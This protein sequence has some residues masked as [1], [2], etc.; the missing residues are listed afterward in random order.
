MQAEVELQPDIAEFVHVD[1]EGSDE[2]QIADIQDLLG[3]DCSILIVSPN[4]TAA[5][6]PAV[7]QACEQLPVIV[8]DRGVNTDC[9][10]TFIHPIGGYAFGATPPSSWSRMSN[11]AATSSPCASCPASTCWRRAGRRP[12][13]SSIKPA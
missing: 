12:R 3:Q 13:P 8:F 10:V 9:P 4:T 5:L 1:A 7:E 2:K 6:T 11:R